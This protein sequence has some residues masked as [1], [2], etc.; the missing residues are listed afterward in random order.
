MMSQKRSPSLSFPRVKRSTNHLALSVRSADRRP[1]E[2][3]GTTSTSSECART[4][5]RD[6]DFEFS[7]IPLTISCP[8]RFIHDRA[9]RVGISM[10]SAKPISAIGVSREREIKSSIVLCL[11][12]R[13]PFVTLGP[14]F[15]VDRLHQCGG[16]ILFPS[17]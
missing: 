15:L 10:W 11:S 2:T 5:S 1:R 12:L 13:L 3:R 9:G 6:T 16:C 14:F 4:R 8:S 17:H 7:F